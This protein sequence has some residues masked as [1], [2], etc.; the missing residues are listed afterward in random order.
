[1]AKI[2]Q[3]INWLIILLVKVYRFTLSPVFRALGAQCRF[4][5]SCSIYL[6]QALR[7]YGLITAVWLTLKR[8]A[9]CHPGCEGGHDPLP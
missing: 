7:E 5:P 3:P 9:K 6:Q 8:L 4:Y 1:M 2:T